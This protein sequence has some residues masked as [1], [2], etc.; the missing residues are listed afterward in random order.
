[1]RRAVTG[2]QGY[3]LPART[4]SV[5]LFIYSAVLI[6]DTLV[7]GGLLLPM[8]QPGCRRRAVTGSQEPGLFLGEV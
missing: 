4:P 7:S 1:M 8:R 2:S 5:S 3:Y 6:P